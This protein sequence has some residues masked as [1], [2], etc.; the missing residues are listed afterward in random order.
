MPF[1]AFKVA[2]DRSCQEFEGGLNHTSAPEPVTRPDAIQQPR[3]L[4]DFL[5]SDPRALNGN[6]EGK[7][8]TK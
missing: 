2:H 8:P 1:E 6:S 4:P 3:S 5:S 7:I